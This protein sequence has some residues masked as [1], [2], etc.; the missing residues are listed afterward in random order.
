MNRDEL[1]AI[2]VQALREAAPGTDVASLD[3]SADVRE[4]LDLDSMD[5]LRFAQKLHD[6]LGV[7]VPETDYA[8]IAA[9]GR[10]VLYL[11]SR[12]GAA[13]AGPS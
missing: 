12:L 4:A 3:D 13:K 8:Q 7:D 10:C 6:R 11:E 1:R 5:V 2:V 9:V